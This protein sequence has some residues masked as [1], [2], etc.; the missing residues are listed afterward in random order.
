MVHM[1]MCKVAIVLQSKSIKLFKD[2]ATDPNLGL[3]N[4][5]YVLISVSGIGWYPMIQMQELF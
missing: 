5:P 4:R 2:V 1:V 3:Y